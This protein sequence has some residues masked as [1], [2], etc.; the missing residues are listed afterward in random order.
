MIADNKLQEGSGGTTKYCWLVQDL[1]DGTA[2]QNN[3]FQK[4]K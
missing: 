2:N 4:P 3:W 1:S